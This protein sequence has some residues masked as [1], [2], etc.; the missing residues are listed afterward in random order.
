MTFRINTLV[1]LTLCFLMIGSLAGGAIADTQ[2]VMSFLG[3]CTLGSEER[4]QDEPYA[5]AAAMGEEGYGYY[6]RNVKDL[7]E[8]DDVTLA[9]LECVLRVNEY[10]SKDKTY[11][12]RGPP[13]Y[14]QI[15]A[16]GSVEAVNL[17][18]NHTLDYGMAGWNDT[19]QAL[20]DAGIAYS[21]MEQA[22][23]Y[24]KDGVRI[25]FLG[26]LRANY[27]THRE[28]FFEYFAQ[29]REDGVNAIVVSLHFG[30]EYSAYH[31][32]G[33]ASMAYYMIDAGADLVLGT[34]P[35][36]LQGM[37]VYNG[38]LIL[39]SLGN[40]VFGGNAE[41][42]SLQ[43]IIPRVTFRFSDDGALLGTR[44][45]IYPAHISGDD[46]GQKHDNNY[47]PVLVRGEQAAAVYALLDQDSV[48]NPVPVLE[49]E[50]DAYREYAWIATAPQQ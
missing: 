7:L 11:I 32:D 12:F 41:V 28:E 38:R 49:T 10:G 8:L 20:T 35:H 15:L 45:R 6:F 1:S 23:I 25:A 44:L 48:E 42:R 9:N 37:E 13:E 34:H 5:F 24:E 39:Y 16:L 47:Q 43:T 31:N 36:V 17:E 46:T 4:L 29:L 26:L 27:F 21:G 3:D 33:Q 22:Y 19:I 40:F 30:E 2:I 50:T 14:A 18:N